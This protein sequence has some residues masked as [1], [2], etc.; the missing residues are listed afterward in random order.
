MLGFRLGQLKLGL[1]DSIFSEIVHFDDEDRLFKKK[2]VRLGQ[3]KLG[4]SDSIFS[5]IVHFDDEDRLF[6]KK[7]S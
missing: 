7:K 6:K 1:S 2:K 3:L 5:E 4:L